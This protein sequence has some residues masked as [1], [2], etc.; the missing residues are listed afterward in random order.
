VPSPFT[1]LRDA[2]RLGAASAVVG[3][4]AWAWELLSRQVPSSPWHVLG[5][6]S[7]IERLALHAWIEACVIFALAPLA[8]QSGLDAA[9]RRARIV[10]VSATIGTVLVFGAMAYSART[11]NLGFQI[12]DASGINYVLLVSRLAGEALRAA[13][14]G[15]SLVTVLRR[16]SD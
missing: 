4:L 2:L 5:L 16:P 14:M 6:P 7:G 12:R 1:S 9:T 8:W 3:A 13:A 10:L 11:G 15:I